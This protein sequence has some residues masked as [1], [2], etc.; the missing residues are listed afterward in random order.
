[1]LKQQLYEP[2]SISVE[3]LDDFPRRMRQNAFFELVYIL[4]GTG[5]HSI[6]DSKMAYQPGEMYLLGTEDR[7]C[8]GI[9]TTTTFFFLRFND[10][11]IKNNGLV[12]DNVQRLEF[13]LQNANQRPGPVVKNETDRPLVHAMVEGMIREQVNR[14]TCWDKL[15]L[16]M[17]NTLIVLVARNIEMFMPQEFTIGD[18]EDKA[19]EIIQY[20]HANIYD[21]EKLKAE[22]ISGQFGI[23]LTYLGRYFK[24]Q[25]GRTM[26]D[27]VAAY[28]LKLVENRLLHS[29]MRIS[30]IVDELGF[31]DESHLNKFFRKHKSVNP[32]DY[33]KAGLPT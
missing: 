23:S 27:Y 3:T 18:K 25:T 21:P 16:G 13:L 30:E 26:Q 12:K 22:L 8:F 4:S 17:V 5:K 15:I 7:H 10:I 29:T 1:M 31:S 32:S 2:Y 24:K 6:N 14:N 9:E 33:R 19:L 11:Y 28:R 20:I